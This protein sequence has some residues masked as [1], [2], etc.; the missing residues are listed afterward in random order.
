M[1]TTN[2]VLVYRIVD[3]IWNHGKLYLFDELFAP[4]FKNTDPGNPLVVDRD[5]L[6]AFAEALRSAFPDFHVVV[7]EMISEGDSVAKCWTL[8]GT[9]QQ[10]FMGIPPT[11]KLVT[12]KGIT[13]YHMAGGRVRECVWAYDNYSLM[14]QLEAIPQAAATP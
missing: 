6:N 9:S 1:P 3:D 7:D 5:G 10:T 13:I 4:D 2:T 14:A 11:G 8:T 12:L